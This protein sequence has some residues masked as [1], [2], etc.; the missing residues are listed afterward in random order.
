MKLPEHLDNL[1]Q[2]TPEPES[3]RTAIEKETK[4]IGETL[5]HILASMPERLP[6]NERAH[7]KKVTTL[8]FRSDGWRM[9]VES[10]NYNPQQR[11]EGTLLRAFRI[12]LVPPERE[13]T[14]D[15]IVNES[16]TGSG[17]KYEPTLLDHEEVRKMMMEMGE[18]I[19]P[20]LEKTQ[21]PTLDNMKKATRILEECWR[22][23]EAGQ[24]DAIFSYVLGPRP[25]Q[26]VAGEGAQEDRVGSG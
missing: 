15:W 18:T 14:W 4:T 23:F 20:R 10:V 2:P 26:R 17:V 19:D 12:D 1:V 5:S 11:N 16:A 25:W 7:F 22:L 9:W 8:L 21:D 6:E 3:Q 24:R 13:A